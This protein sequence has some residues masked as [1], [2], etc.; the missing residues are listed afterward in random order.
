MKALRRL[1]HLDRGGE[2]RRPPAS[3]REE[4]H[5]VS[6]DSGR[7]AKHHTPPEKRTLKQCRAEEN[8]HGGNVFLTHFCG[9]TEEGKNQRVSAGFGGDEKHLDASVSIKAAYTRAISGKSALKRDSV[10]YSFVGFSLI[11]ASPVSLKKEEKIGAH[12]L[13]ARPLMNL[14]NWC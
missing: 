12:R 6:W 14:R 9:E 2:G 11:A 13:K 7:T 5:S 4:Q 1:K 10:S 8:K 3:R